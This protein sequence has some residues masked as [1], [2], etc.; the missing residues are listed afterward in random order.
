MNK[1]NHKFHIQ[2]FKHSQGLGLI[3]ILISILVLGVGALGVASM[4]ITGLKYN[5]GAYARSQA[6]LISSDMMDRMRANRQ[7][8]NNPGS[9]DYEIPVLVNTTGRTIFPTD[10]YST[11]CSG[12]EMASFDTWFFLRQIEDQLPFGRGQI[13]IDDTGDQRLYQI[14]IEWRNVANSQERDGF[15]PTDDELS[16]FTFSSTL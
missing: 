7:L 10:C 5:T 13:T 4:Q 8:A 12:A 16:R 2:N 6:A 9:L 1:L 14:T 3:E 15:T 11:P